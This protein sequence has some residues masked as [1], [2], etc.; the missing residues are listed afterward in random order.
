MP[1]V[2]WGTGWFIGIALASALRLPLEFL[3]PA[4][5]VPTVGLF[6]WR[7]NHGARLISFTIDGKI[8]E[9]PRF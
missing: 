8:N 6:L 4:F 9:P 1:L 3:L 2:Y 7:H 5:V